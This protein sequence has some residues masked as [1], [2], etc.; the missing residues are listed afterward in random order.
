MMLARHPELKAEIV[1]AQDGVT[2]SLGV[3]LA[4]ELTHSNLDHSPQAKLMDTI[5]CQVTF[6]QFHPTS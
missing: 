4:P 3:S 6:R 2:M 1:R 5:L